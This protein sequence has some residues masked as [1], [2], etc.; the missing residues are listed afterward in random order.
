MGIE[1][2]QNVMTILE[3]KEPDRGSLANPEVFKNEG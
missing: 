2:A 1:A 3:G